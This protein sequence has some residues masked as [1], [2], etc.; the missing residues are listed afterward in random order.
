MEQ[1]TL[2]CGANSAKPV[3]DD[4]MHSI[5]DLHESSNATVASQLA[6]ASSGTL[7]GR[8]EGEQ[9]TSANPTQF[10]VMCQFP[11]CDTSAKKLARLLAANLQRLDP[12]T[13]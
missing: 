12:G 10:S 8:R 2:R 9:L 13:L 1:S 7:G 5:V 6:A 4:Q 3:N 11:R